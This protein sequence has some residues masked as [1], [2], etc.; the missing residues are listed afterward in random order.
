MSQPSRHVWR[1]GAPLGGAEE[2]TARAIS[3]YA[4]YA[5]LLS[6]QMPPPKSK[7]FSSPLFG[8]LKFKEIA[9]AKRIG[10]LN[11]IQ[12]PE[13]PGSKASWILG[14]EQRAPPPA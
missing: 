13:H 5:R 7:L 8:R 12:T 4:Q 14:A 9:A 11:Y 10:L 2:Q 1:K 3:A 6:L